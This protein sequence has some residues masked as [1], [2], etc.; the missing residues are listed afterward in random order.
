MRAVDLFA[1]LPTLR[2][3]GL[4]V[5]GTDTEVG[6]TVAACL[7]AD[8]LR[9]QARARGAGERVGVLKP[10]ASGCRL[11]RERLVSPD[12]EAL[13]HAADFDPNVGDL[14]VVCP[15]RVRPPLAPAVALERSGGELDVEAVARAM[16]RQDEACRWIVVEGIGGVLTPLARTRRGLVTALD[17]M[18]ALDYPVVVVARAG[19]GTLNHTALTCQA[20]RQRGLRIAGVVVNGYEPDSSD[21]SMES[22]RRWLGIVAQAPVLAVLPL[23]PRWDVK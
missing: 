10:F 22:N 12:A 2:A 3:P 1:S 8:Q 14:D 6:K 17:C 13:A 5:A 20:I 11:E 15:V 9:R 23:V 16:R 7:I 4:F 19:L 18:E 21:P